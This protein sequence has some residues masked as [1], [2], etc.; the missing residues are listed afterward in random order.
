MIDTGLDGKTALITGANHGIG[1][2]IANALADQG[3]SVFLHYF[4][5]QKDLPLENLFDA[6]GESLYKARQSQTADHIVH[7]INE[8]GGN[9]VAWECDLGQPNNIC[10]LFEEA[11]RKFEHIDILVNNAASWAADTFSPCE[12][13]AEDRIGRVLATI[14]E[15]TVDLHFNVITRGTA[16]LMAEYARRYA[17]GD[18]K[19]GRIINI[20]TSGSYCFPEEVS[21]AAAKSAVESYSRSAAKELGQYG[22]TVNVVS[23][24]AIQT[25]WI[26]ANFEREIAAQTPLRRAGQPDDVAD[27]VVFLC[28]QQARWVTGQLIRVGGGSI[29]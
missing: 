5:P 1:A 19:W 6:P 4:R 13:N 17:S 21:Y 28:S 15:H 23:P 14:S 3:V 22:I 7:L 24:G 27:V 29:V 10:K 2:A 16:L 26:D 9:A 25:G 18:L 20:S 11:Q 8:R 12:D